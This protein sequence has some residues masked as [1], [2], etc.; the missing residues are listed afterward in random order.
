MTADTIATVQAAYRHL[1]DDAR[2]VFSHG[3]DGIEAAVARPMSLDEAVALSK[4]MI[5]NAAERV[6]RL[7]LIGEKSR[8]KSSRRS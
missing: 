1:A 2:N 3:I 5:A 4:E 6:M 7:I 8:K